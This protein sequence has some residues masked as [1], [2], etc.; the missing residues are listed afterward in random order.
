MGS[1]DTASNDT[2]VPGGLGDNDATA[3]VPR[4]L[5]PEPAIRPL[6]LSVAQEGRYEMLDEL[7]E[8]GMGKVVSAF[9]RVMQREIAIKKVRA[10]RLA[11]D[12]IVPM[13]VEEARTQGRLD[14]PAVVPVFDLGLG[15]DG[16]PFFTMR[17]VEGV[18]LKQI[19]ERRAAGDGADDEALGVRRLLSNFARICLTVDYAHSRGVLHGDLKPGNLMFGT[20]GEVYVLD[21]GGAR[22][23]SADTE[24]DTDDTSP[25]VGSPPYMA[26]ELVGGDRTPRKQSD[27]YALGV[28]LFEILTGRRLERRRDPDLDDP[29]VPP[30]LQTSIARAVAYEV[31]DRYSTARELA[32]EVERFLDGAR[33]LERR[34]EQSRERT[35]AAEALLRGGNGVAERREA[36]AAI[37]RALALD[38]D[39]RRA[40]EVFLEIADKPPEQDPPEVE[41]QMREYHRATMTRVARLAAFVYVALFLSA[42]LFL[43]QTVASTTPLIAFYGLLLV[44]AASAW[45]MKTT[46]RGSFFVVC[47]LASSAGLGATASLFGP[48]FIMPMFAAVNVS[49]FALLAR[50]RAMVLTAVVGIALVVAPVTLEL[51]GLLPASYDFIGGG[52]LIRSGVMVLERGPTTILLIIMNLMSM[53]TMLSYIFLSARATEA[54]QRKMFAQTWHFR[55]LVPTAPRS[56]S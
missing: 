11:V 27:I 56:D 30:E 42:P 21:W 28:T 29:A 54:V 9:D 39:N 36:V 4:A 20:Y 32:D 8:G 10:D 45:A 35:E 44:S 7:G 16:Q 48:L 25:T 38:P 31:G 17:H 49:A 46:G 47:L 24:V 13:F 6:D 51:T 37:G 5:A 19:L 1:K 2:T 41:E 18:S 26:P 43:S 3:V 40:F 22:S 52:M 12:G 14:H 50:G 23:L 15:Q 34:R 33:D 53:L 55:Q